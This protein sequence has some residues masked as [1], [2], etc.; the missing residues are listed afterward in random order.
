[1][2]GRP[3]TIIGAVVALV[4][5][6]AF[7]LLGNRGGGGAA[8][9]GTPVTLKPVVVAARDVNSRV[10]LTAA[11]LK[12]TKLA[13]VPPQSFDKTADLVGLVPV[14][15]IYAG[16]PLTANIVVSSPGQVTGAQA[17][18][19]PIPTGFV[20]KTIPTGELQGVAGFIQAGD[21]ITIEALVTAGTFTNERTIF[22]NVHVLRLGQA[23]AQPAP[24]AK[25]QPTPAP[26]SLVASSLTVVVTQC[27]AEILDWFIANGTVKYTLESYHDYQP[28]DVSV[29]SSCPTVDA[30]N[31]PVTANTIK[32]KYPGLLP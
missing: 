25:G 4:A 27:Q 26:Y 32:S 12:L 22:T 31:S 17:A 5:L 6:G 30:A 23:A 2:S 11:D 14:V 19:L 15:N 3:F 18:F 20:A 8:G 13:D 9:G 1:M 16:Q 28:K 10:P 29:D 7:L 21:Y 24:P